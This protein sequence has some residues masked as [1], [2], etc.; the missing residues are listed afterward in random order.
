MF[1]RLIRIISRSAVLLLL[2]WSCRK[3]SSVPVDAP[4]NLTPYSIT[5]PYYFPILELPANNPLTLEGI[6]L[7]RH[8]YYDTILSRDGRACANC[9][10]QASAFTTYTSNALAHINL[11]WNNSFLWNGKVQG[12]MEDIMMFEVEQFF[13]TDVAKM[14]RSVF[15][16]KEFKK[17]YN[18]DTITPQLLSYAL[19]Q[20][21]RAM[22]SKNSL[23]DKFFLHTASLNASQT[24]GFNIFTTEKGDC[25]HC[26][27]LGLFTDN[28]FHNIG[29]DSIFIGVNVGR[30]NVTGKES[31]LGHFK[32]PTLRNIELTAPYMHDGRYTTLEEVVDH[33]DSKVKH[34]N[35]LDPIMTK[36]SKLYGLGLTSQ[37]KADLVAF[38]KTLTDTS[39]TNN[40]LLQ[41]P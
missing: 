20:F 7:G 29:L 1:L 12:S 18:S 16:R 41:K 40:P 39:F 3:E 37:D 33:Y 27:S 5:Y 13:N 4:V 36:P 31:D 15:Y 34:S 2:F 6:D 19:S 22:V 38:L 23:C 24:R 8:L 17:V 11:G 10:F 9:H 32:T 30:Y 28:K 26:H 25:F 21:F 35:T 14:N